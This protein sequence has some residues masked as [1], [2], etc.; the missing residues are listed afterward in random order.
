MVNLAESSS[1]NFFVA[2]QCFL[3]DKYLHFEG[4][5]V[6]LHLLGMLSCISLC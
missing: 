2:V 4:E 6:L 5:S 1:L 3:E